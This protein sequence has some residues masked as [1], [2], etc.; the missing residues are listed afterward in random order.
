MVNA[1]LKMFLMRAM[2]EALRRKLALGFKLTAEN[3]T[4][5][6]RFHDALSSLAA[7]WKLRPPRDHETVIQDL[8]AATLSEF[9]AQS[10]AIFAH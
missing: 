7:V 8:R 2:P 9:R 5:L 1:L 10:I 4:F 6:N 3:S